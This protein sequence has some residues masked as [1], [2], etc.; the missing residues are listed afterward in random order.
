MRS[1][2]SLLAAGLV[3]AL[4]MLT[5]CA[6]PQL[7][8]EMSREVTLIPPT[9]SS[10]ALEPSGRLDTSE[11]AH[12]IKVTMTGDPDL[13]AT[14][15]L[16]GRLQ[17]RMQETEPG[18]YVGSFEVQAGETG[19]VGVIG[20]LVHESSGARQEFRLEEG[21]VLFALPPPPACGED[22]ARQLEEEL[23]SLTVHFEFDRFDITPEAGARLLAGKERLASRPAC[24]LYLHGHADEI[25]TEQYNLDLSEKRA[26]EVARFLESSLGIPGDHLAIR[27]HG[28]SR[29]LDT[30]GTDEA[31][32]RNRRVEFHAVA[33]D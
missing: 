27:F 16:K 17:A 28:E 23:E 7:K 26:R 9:I 3:S 15:D 11:Q 19:T 4:V 6:T 14:F 29:P 25:G 31:R 20:Q 22:V 8:L 21:L 13:R 2:T 10:L 1:R 33:A 12:I 18:V 32:A 24:T 30:A 5:T